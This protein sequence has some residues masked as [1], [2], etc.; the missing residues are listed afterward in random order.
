MM[1]PFVGITL[2]GADAPMNVRHGGDPLE[3]E[4]KL[5]SVG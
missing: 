5:G 3:D 2:P 1:A 4:R